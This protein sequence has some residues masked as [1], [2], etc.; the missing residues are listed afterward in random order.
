M[1]AFL[2]ELSSQMKAIW[3]RLDSGQRMTVAS[4][5][6][7]TIIGLGALLWYSSR[8]D[9]RR[10]DDFADPQNMLRA[11][12]ALDSALIDWETRGRVLLVKSSQH[13][14][15]RN[16]LFLEGLTDEAPGIG[17]FIDDGILQDK[18]GREAAMVERKRVQAEA[19]VRAIDS[20]KDV[21]VTANAPKSAVM[22][23]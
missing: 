8:P 23:R 9:Y 13:A 21:I 15:A 3:A 20:I 16:I 22:A 7:A 6:F 1:S 18:A 5:M 12:A 19:A 17:T 14:K 4:V 10:L 11:E 2:A